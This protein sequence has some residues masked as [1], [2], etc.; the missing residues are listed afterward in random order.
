MPVIDLGFRLVA[1]HAQLVGVDDHDIIAGIDM[2]G[3]D[4]LVLAAQTMGDLG[5]EAPQNLVRC[6]DHDPVVGYLVGLS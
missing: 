1:R 2:G 5:S 6:V 4:R 3:V